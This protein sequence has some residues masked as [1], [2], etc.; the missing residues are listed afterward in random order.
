[1]TAKARRAEHRAQM[2]KWAQDNPTGY[3][4]DVIAAGPRAVE[5]RVDRDVVW[6]AISSL[7]SIDLRWWRGQPEVVAAVRAARRAAL[8]AD[9]AIGHAMR[10][11]RPR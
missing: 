10:Q 3:A 1:M 6:D 9:R 5:H 2:L 7:R 4:S 11:E 8:D